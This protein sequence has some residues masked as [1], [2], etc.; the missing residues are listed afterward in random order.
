MRA[1]KLKIVTPHDVAVRE[2]RGV[3]WRR[4]L[5]ITWVVMGWLLRT[6][7]EMVTLAFAVVLFFVSLLLIMMGVLGHFW[8]GPPRWND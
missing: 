2:R 5:R 4:I 3:P 6:L 7:W 8:G 1:V